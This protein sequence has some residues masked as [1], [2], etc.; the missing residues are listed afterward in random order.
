V[1]NGAIAAH[2]YLPEWLR[3]EFLTRIGVSGQGKEIGIRPVAVLDFGLA[4]LKGGYERRLSNSLF[5][6]NQARVETQGFG[7]SLQ[8]VL[9]PWV[10]FG[11]NIARRI[12][13]GF[14]QDGVPRPAASFTTTTW[15]GFV[16]VRPYIEN[17]L[18]GLGYNHTYFENFNIDSFNEPEHT[19]HTQ[20]FA[21]AKYLLWD[22]LYLKYVL[23]YANADIEERNDQDASDDG[24][25]N[26]SLSHRLRVMLLY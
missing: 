17:T 8:F 4:K 13:D 16:N 20:M 3:F 23:A 10:E 5:E 6:G 1:N 24:F 12:E 15:G 26:K 7:G 14:E 18:I 19:T 11:G 22:S 2:W 25:T 9:D 21:A